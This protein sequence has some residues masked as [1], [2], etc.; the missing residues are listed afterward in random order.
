MVLWSSVSGPVHLCEWGT[1]NMCGLPLVE[2]TH[3]QGCPPVAP[4]VFRGNAV[5]RAM[6][7]T[8]GSC[9]GGGEKKL[10]EFTT[11]MR[12]FQFNCLLQGLCNS[13][14]SFMRLMMGIFGDQHFLTQLCYLDG[15][16]VCAP[17]EEEAAGTWV[18]VVPQETLPS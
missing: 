6:D 2:C 8:S 18:E 10:T 3:G 12:L 11:P 5:F 17:N 4:P 13:P 1:Q 16:F 7:L 9:H 15:L 14:T